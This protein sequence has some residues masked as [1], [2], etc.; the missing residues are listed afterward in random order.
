MIMKRLSWKHTL[1]ITVTIIFILSL[2][3]CGTASIPPANALPVT[4]QASPQNDYYFSR[5]GQ[6]PDK[7][8]VSLINSAKSTLDIAIYS[9]TQK[10]IVNSILD[11]KQRGVTVRFI[12][13]RSEAKTKAQAAELAR[14]KKATIPIKENT[15]PGLMHLKVS[16]IDGSIVTTG[17]YNY[18]Q[19]ASTE[20]DEVF[21]V[22]H[23][24]DAAAKFESQFERMW[25]DT[26]DFA[27]LK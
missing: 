23:D 12:T 25:N 5:A 22:I 16:I 10:D 24:T 3:G 19:A 20:N 11:A 8:L 7:A 27:A 18:T 6:H 26:K 13:D 14:L 21:V 1:C 15:H 4:A 2:F 9:L 17:S